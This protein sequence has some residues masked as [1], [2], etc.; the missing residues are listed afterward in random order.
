M[1]LEAEFWV[2]LAFVVFLGRARLSRRAPHARRS[3]STSAPTASR[4]SSTRRAGSRTR[5]PQLLAEYQRKQQRGRERGAGDRRRRQGRGR[6]ARRRGQGQDRGIRRPPHQ[7]GGD[8]DRAGRGAGR[9]R[10]ARRRRRSR[11]RR[12][13]EDPQRRQAKGKLAAELI[14]KGIDDVRKKAEL[15]GGRCARSSPLPDPF[16]DGKA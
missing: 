12:R 7:D 5:P 9:R 6:A 2:A 10:R 11:R 15:V 4:R 14:A 13:R 16:R 3:R 8:Q 1:L